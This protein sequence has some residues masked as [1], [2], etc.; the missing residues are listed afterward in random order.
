[1]SDDEW[2]LILKIKESVMV[3]FIFHGVQLSWLLL[4]PKLVN[5]NIS[6]PVDVSPPITSSSITIIL[7]SR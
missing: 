2:Q 6:P 5:M 1:M 4:L 7:Q 3:C